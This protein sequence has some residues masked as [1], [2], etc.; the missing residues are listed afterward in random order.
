MCDAARKMPIPVLTELWICH[1]MKYKEL[2]DN[3]KVSKNSGPKIIE[4]FAFSKISPMNSCY[5]TG[6]LQTEK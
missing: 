1:A 3:T 6:Y 4:T 2:P 5:F